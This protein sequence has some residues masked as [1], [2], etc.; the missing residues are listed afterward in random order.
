MIEIAT[1]TTLL[2]LSKAL[3]RF[4][5]FN[6]F[7]FQANELILELDFEGIFQLATFHPEYQFEG[8][9]IDDITNYTNRAPYPVL[10]ILRESSIEKA[11]IDYPN[12]DVIFEN[13]IKTMEKLGARGLK[14]LLN[15]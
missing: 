6:D 12:P 4:L 13:N 1:A 9:D 5:D 7:T 10:Q 14:E 8:S 3:P 15:K 2:I 11:L